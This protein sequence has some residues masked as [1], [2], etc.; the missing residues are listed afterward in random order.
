[1]YANRATT[2]VSLVTLLGGSRGW[3]YNSMVQGNMGGDRAVVVEGSTATLENC[4][5]SQNPSTTGILGSAGAIVQYSDAW[6][7]DVDFSGT[8][9]SGGTNISADP[10]FTDA[11]G[12]DFTL[13]TGFSPAIDVGNPLAGYND[14]DGTRNDLGAFGGPGGAW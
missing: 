1:M 5:V 6:G 7:N 10:R 8:A 4:I 9:T 11:L 3:I 13:M 14:L 12:G 2:D